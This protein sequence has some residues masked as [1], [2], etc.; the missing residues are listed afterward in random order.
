M[1]SNK[2][3]SPYP[4]SP[5]ILREIAKHFG[6]KTKRFDDYA[7]KGHHDE[8][9]HRQLIK[10]AFV[11][12]AG[13]SS[14]KLG[15]RV[16]EYLKRAFSQYHGQVLQTW[17][18]GLERDNLEHPLLETFTVFGLGA[19]N[20]ITHGIRRPEFAEWF[21]EDKLLPYT[22]RWIEQTHTSFTEVSSQL[23]PDRQRAL[24]KWK[25]GQHIPSFNL[26]QKF[27]AELQEAGL[28][29][30]DCE[31][32]FTLLIAA[33]TVDSFL[34]EDETGKRIE[35]LRHHIE[36][37]GDRFIDVWGGQKQDFKSLALANDLARKAEAAL[38]VGPPTLNKEKLGYIRKSLDAAW[39]KHRKEGH[40]DT[41]LFVLHRVEGKYATVIGDK[42]TALKNYKKAFEYALY[43]AGKEQLKIIHEALAVAAICEDRVFLKKLKSQA[44]AFDL[45]HYFEADQ[46]NPLQGNQSSRSKDN[47][48]EDWEVGQWKET[49]P[50]LFP[51]SVWPI[52]EHAPVIIVKDNLSPDPSKPN[53]ERQIS[54]GKTKTLPDMVLFSE[55]NNKDAVKELLEAEADISQMSKEGE[56]C[57]LMAIQEVNPTLLP[58]SSGDDELFHLI[59]ERA[60]KDRR[61]KN[62]DCTVLKMIN[63]PTVKRKLTPLGCAVET[64]RVDI[65]EKVLK[66]GANVDQRFG[67]DQRTP[68][69]H[70]IGLMDRASDA[71]RFK[72]TYANYVASAPIEVQRE[73]IRRYTGA[74]PPEDL[75]PRHPMIHDAVM[76]IMIEQFE[77]VSQDDLWNIA[78]LLLSYG[79]SP[80][81]RC[82]N[83]LVSDF[84]PLMLAIE[85]DDV[86]LFRLMKGKYAGDTDLSCY[87]H[88][89]N[90]FYRCNEIA[91]HW[92]SKK[93][94]EAMN[95]ISP[96]HCRQQ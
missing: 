53:R 27:T 56:S 65:V 43:T 58:F 34:G 81:T 11:Q 40:K 95:C 76:E 42:K 89:N 64:G 44:I 51:Q 57:L 3:T 12:R 61:T 94:L 83:E 22:F 72:E 32:V 52:D 46:P 5:E 21:S 73:T 49:F 85:I 79:A 36:V 13:N 19:I 28:P 74:V 70:C 33:R 30:E 54:E 87:S 23:T 63:T 50:Q 77:K 66:L 71:K 78:K 60:L 10:Q 37:T 38:D 24:R 69:Y 90:E 8:N 80:N 84:T 91:W 41:L 59:Y 20:F 31:Q 18:G 45:Y 29:P 6:T 39:E 67:L 88:T 96:E 35:M 26:I 62:P 9:T 48:V 55:W 1:P 4:P 82:S 25:S 17:V 7:R 68:L 86:E 2:Y 47:F 16:E 14:Y 15:K 92:G 75:G 93:I